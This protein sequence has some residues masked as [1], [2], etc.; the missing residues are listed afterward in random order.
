MDQVF[1]VRSTLLSDIKVNVGL[2]AVKKQC[3]FCVYFENALILVC[4]AGRRMTHGRI[5]RGPLHTECDLSVPREIRQVREHPAR[6]ASFGIHKGCCVTT[7]S[8]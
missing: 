2:W 1:K 3:E 5:T 8:T 6:L 7:S 4:F